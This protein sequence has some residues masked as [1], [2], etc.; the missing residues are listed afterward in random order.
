MSKAKKKRPVE[1]KTT[2]NLGENKN[3]HTTR[4]KIEDILNQRDFDKL[5]EL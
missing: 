3:I 5:Y 2:E 4:R 1:K